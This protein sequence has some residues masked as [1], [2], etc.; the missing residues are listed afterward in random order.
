MAGT[1]D[2]K[3]VCRA[4][5]SETGPM[6][7]LFMV[8]TAEMFKLCTSVEVSSTFITKTSLLIHSYNKFL[9]LARILHF[10]LHSGYKGMASYSNK[11]MKLLE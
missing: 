8:C 2:F 4:C 5:L 7:D 3:K 6:K 11:N 1:L 9:F 10:Y